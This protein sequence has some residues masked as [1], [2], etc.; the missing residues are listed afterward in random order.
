MD[1]DEDFRRTFNTVRE[2]PKT[3]DDL[4]ERDDPKHNWLKP[5]HLNPIR[6]AD[7]ERIEKLLP[8]RIDALNDR[9]EPEEQR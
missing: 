9:A 6:A 7:R 4:I 8:R 2:D 5:E 1:S 3:V